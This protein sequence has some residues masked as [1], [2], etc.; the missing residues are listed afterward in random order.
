MVTLPLVLLAIP[1][2]C[3]GY[4]TI[5]YMLF[6][7]FF[8]DAI[9][10]NASLHPAMAELREAFHSPMAMAEHALT[11]VPFVLAVAGVLT[12]FFLYMVQPSLP[13]LIQRQLTPLHTLLLNKYF[14]D[15]FNEK[16]LAR[17][18]RWL[19]NGLWKGGDQGVIDG[20][21]VNGSWRLIGKVALVARR[22][23]TGFL[24]HYALLFG[25]ITWFVWL[26]P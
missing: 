12:A 15:D 16:V 24:Y 23:Q 10:V 6:G 26:K 18:T 13:G 4:F 5:E 11:S 21:L 1:S 14:L 20:W 2:V 25:L 9:S 19:A 22:L 7:E 3:I 8:K 17:G